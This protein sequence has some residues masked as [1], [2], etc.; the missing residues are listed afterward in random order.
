MADSLLVIYEKNKFL[1]T[2]EKLELLRNLSFNETNN[3]QKSIKFAEELILFSHQEKNYLYLYRGYIQKG[4]KLRLLGELKEALESYFKSLDA[5]TKA[6]LPTGQGLAYSTIADVYSEFGNSK[7]AQI[8]YAKAV[9]IL[10]KTNDTIGLASTL[11]NSGDAYINSGN[12]L[13]AKEKTEEAKT[14]FKQVHYESG[15]AYALG[16]LGMIYAKQ[17]NDKQAEINITKAIKLLE[18]IEDYYPICVYLTY[19]SD[20]YLEKGNKTAA[21]NYLINSLSLAKTHGLK[22]EI[23]EANLKLSQLYDKLGKP[24]ESLG[25]LQNHIIYRDSLKNLETVQKIA[26]MRTD[27]EVSQK[28]AEVDLLSQQKKNQRIV[29]FATIIALGC[30]A[31]VAFGLYRR[32]KFVQ[33]TNKIIDYERKRS[34]DLLRNI[35]PESTAEELKVNGKVKAKRFQSVTVLFTDF[36]GFTHYAENLPPEKLVESVDF[37]FSKF[38]EII[39]KYELEKIKTIG[40]AY[41]CAG[42]LP[43]PTEDHALKTVQAAIEIASFVEETRRL[44][45]FNETSFEIRLGINSGPVVAGVVGTKKF[46]YDI[47]GDTV[48]I[49]SRLESNS[50]SGKINISEST[51][52]LVKDTFDC[53]YRGEIIVKNKGLMKMYFLNPVQVKKRI[54]P[55]VSSLLQTTI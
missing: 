33:K 42:G 10:R 7:N 27:F 13:L 26:D 15:E 55:A 16:N 39:E 40:D 49:A 44:N 38:D 23:S 17:G 50:E 43:F 2:T 12:L 11:L 52:A 48:N 34:D 41:M 21:L 53:E 18:K 46:A 9:K 31:F 24:K 3:L 35:L 22:K 25:H 37:Y 45:A 47:W 28:Q 51:Y 4:N 20:I 54:T 14:I 36:H 29:V 19:M 5:A 6:K 30:I 8:Y 32:N 1:S